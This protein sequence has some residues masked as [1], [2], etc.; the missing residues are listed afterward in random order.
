[1]P[2][3]ISYLAGEGYSGKS[4]SMDHEPTTFIRKKDQMLI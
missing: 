2:L 1:M 3:D 4:F